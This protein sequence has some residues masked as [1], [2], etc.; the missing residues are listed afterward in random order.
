MYIPNI[1]TDYDYTTS[2]NYT[3]KLKRYDN[4]TITNYTTFEI[5]DNNIFF[6]YLL[7]SIPSRILLFSLKS[8]MI[9]TLIKPLLG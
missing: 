7:L 8:L 1:T 6:K 3:D 4:I 9:Y 2:I 5:E